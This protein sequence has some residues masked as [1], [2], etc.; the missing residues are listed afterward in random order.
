MARAYL[1]P[2]LPAL[3]LPVVS[4]NIGYGQRN[5]TYFL[6]DA[7]GTRYIL[8]KRPS[9]T[10]ISP[11]AHQVDREFRVLEA[12]GKTDF[13]VPK[14]YCLCEDEG[15]IGTS[16]YVMQ[17]IKGRILTDPTLAELPP[18]RPWFS[19]IETIA[20][21]HR[22]DPV[23]IGLEAFGKQTNFYERQCSTFSRIEAQQTAVRDKDTGALL[24]CAHARYDDM[25]GFVR[26]NLPRDRSGI[27]HGDYKFDNIILHPS[28]PT[29][30]AVLD[31]E[32]S[33]LGNPLMDIV[34]LLSPYWFNPD[35]AY[36]PPNHNAHAMPSE[37]EL[38]DRY[39]KLAGYDPIN[40]RWHVAQMFHLIRG[41]TISHEIQARTITG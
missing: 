16:F 6:D 4:I 8:R 34:Y 5:S 13:P 39:T 30:S 33:T 19:A 22:I 21:L 20:K 25:V 35:P 9:G 36:A 1:K 17:F 14:V 2:R 24:G 12:L 40:E 41:G 37:K 11:V 23:A 28:E 32:L 15:L 31:W 29:V 10:I 3:K 7:G 38:L 27:V 26:R 18:P